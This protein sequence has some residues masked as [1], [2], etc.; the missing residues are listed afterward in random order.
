[1]RKWLLILLVFGVAASAAVQA[2]EGRR[3]LS[4]RRSDRRGRRERLSYALLMERAQMLERDAKINEKD[5]RKE[6]ANALRIVAEAHRKFAKVVKS[7]DRIKIRQAKREFHNTIR[8]YKQYL[9]EKPGAEEDARRDEKTDDR[10]SRR[11]DSSG[12]SSSSSKT[13]GK[14]SR[15]AL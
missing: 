3:S 13:E 12:S 4:D 15:P 10:G 1:M 9:P 6:E 8:K 5:G 7:G 14:V 11:D 2:E